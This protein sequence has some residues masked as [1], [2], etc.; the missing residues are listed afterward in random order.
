MKPR[1]KQLAFPKGSRVRLNDDGMQQTHVLKNRS[2]VVTGYGHDGETIY[3]RWD[4][5][6]AP[7]PWFCA[8]LIP[9][10]R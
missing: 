1:G 8:H 2:G 6:R 7:Q 4:D 3:V 9:D 5:H 10:P